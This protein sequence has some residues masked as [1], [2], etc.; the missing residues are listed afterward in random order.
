M[1]WHYRDPP[2]VWLLVGAYVSH[3]LEEYLAGFPRWVAVIAGRPMPTEVFIGINA[4][5]FVGMV[6]A[7]RAAIRNETLGW[8]AVAIATVL[9]VN[10][11]AHLGASLLTASYSPGLFTGVV[12]YMPI[13]QLLLLRA[14]HQAPEALFWQ[15]VGA[16]LAAHI[17]VTTAALALG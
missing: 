12:L 10:A 8:L 6:L 5:A 3:V 11:L 7:A 17:V 14:W 4:V 2:L 15:G 13:A 16:G 9:L 1:R